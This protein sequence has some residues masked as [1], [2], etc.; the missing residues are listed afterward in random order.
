MSEFEK[1]REILGEILDF[2]VEEITPET[3]LVRELDAESIDLLEVALEL[4]S[5]FGVEVRDDDIFLRNLRGLIVG[6]D[7]NGKDASAAIVENLPH[8]TNE[9][10][11]EMLKDLKEG[12]VLKVKDLVSYVRY[13]SR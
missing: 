4:S 12:P 10:A 3:Y 5:G 8:I 2:D 11:G 13:L 7:E 9:R 1:V 6:A